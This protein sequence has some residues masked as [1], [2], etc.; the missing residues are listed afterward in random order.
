MAALARGL[1]MSSETTSAAD[2]SLF[3]AELR[4]VMPDALRLATA[5]LSN[6]IEAEDAVQEACMLAWQRRANRRPG[7]QLRPWL[8][9]IVANRCR[10]AR[11]G[12]WWHT[13][14]V[15][16]V[17]V[18]GR[19]DPVDASDLI[20]MRDAL[21]KLRYRVRFAIVLRYYLDLS[22][23]DVAS[24][25]GCSVGAAKAL[26][27]RGTESLGRTLGVEAGHVDA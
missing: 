13:V 21:N 10:E 15:A 4:P 18:D 20:T 19:A 17:L 26:V 12:R 5:M 25:M 1:G 3:E 8:L 2:A 11:R 9:G 7:T 27:H 23:D 6:P 14:R 22:F 24:T 16:E